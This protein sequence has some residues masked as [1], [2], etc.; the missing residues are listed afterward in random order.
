MSYILTKSKPLFD[1]TT[2]LDER[3]D[4]LLWFAT[5]EIVD[6]ERNAGEY[7]AFETKISALLTLMKIAEAMLTIKDK[8]YSQY[9]RFV[10]HTLILLWA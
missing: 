4:D 7:S 5:D 1:T 6:I 8:R 3:C 2:G 10:T 9:I